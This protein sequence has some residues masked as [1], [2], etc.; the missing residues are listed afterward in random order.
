MRF[1]HFSIVLNRKS[2]L[3]FILVYF[4]ISMVLAQQNTVSENTGTEAQISPPV[5]DTTVAGYAKQKK[6][7]ITGAITTVKSDEFNKGNIN[8]PLQLIQGKVA[9]IGISKPGGD[10]NGL[11]DIRI[12]G[13]NTINATANPLIVID[14]IADG[15]LDNVDPNDIESITVLKDASAAAIYGTRASNGVL[16]VTTKR[17]IKGSAVEYN[18]FVTTESVAKN[19]LS[20]NSAG[21]RALSAE[22]GLGTDFGNNT[23]WF[24]EIEQRAISQVHNISI[25]GGTDK[26][27][28]RASVNFRQGE[29]IEIHTG[30]SQ[31]NGRFNLSQK[32]INDKLTLDLNLSATE[33]KSQYGFREAFKY[34][35]IFNP[36]AP[37]R[38]NDP[39]YSIYDGYFQQTLFDYY[40]PVAILDLNTNDGKNSVLNLS[41]KGTYEVLEGLK[42]D[43]LYSFQSMGNLK[44]EYYDKNDFWIGIN[45][46][47]YASRQKDNLSFQLFETTA[48][49][50]GDLSSDISLS[51]HG[52][53]SYQDFTQEGFNVNGGNFLTD[54]FSYNNLSAALDFNNG[55][56]IADSYKK[57]NKLIAFF[58]QFTL[59][60][61]SLWFVSA[62]SRYEGSSRFGSSRKWGLFPSI[63]TGIELANFINKKS[64]NSL[65]L[66]MGY[67]ITGN[68]PKDSYLSLLHLEQIGS[69]LYNG[70]YIPAYE[71]FSN[72]NP[73]LKWEQNNEFNIGAD[74]ALFGFRLSGS[75]DIYN[76][77][78]TDLLYRYYSVNPNDYYYYTWM[79]L[80]EISN[81]G[82]ELTLNYKVF[83]KS[84]FTYITALSLSR[85]KNILVSL[86]GT[87]NGI[88]IKPEIYDM[89]YMGSPG[90]SSPPVIRIEEGKPIG[91]I[92]AYTF[93]EIDENGNLLLEDISGPNKVP[94]GYV[95]SYDRSVVGNGLPKILLG[96][97]NSFIYKN[98]D[99]NIFFRGVFGHDLINSNRA[100]YESPNVIS[101]YNPQRTTT[102]MRNPKTGALQNTYY[103]LFSSIHV[104]N[105]SFVSLDNLNLGYSINLPDNKEISKIRFYFAGNNL[106]YLT[107]YKGSDPNPRY[108]DNE[109]NTY[110]PL[111]AGIDRRETWPRTRS[112]SFGVNV[113]F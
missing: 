106:F 44:S 35:T 25:V 101:S 22:T 15:S 112:V 78:S 96:F 72:E 1:L 12:R 51:A 18:F 37:V 16:L 70:T 87:Y 4:T 10:P 29:G 64:V 111:I 20:M 98:W 7:N 100:F 57:T 84:D 47:G 80:G 77:K 36:T 107:G 31:F 49:Y 58:G 33:R 6:K 50:S 90:G 63:G 75:F 67:G 56:G 88:S 66:R 103:G 11:Y 27:I 14:G 19:P 99:L 28:Y 8:N 32:A 43:A 46:N 93:K 68:Q 17:G 40:N 55:Y 62:S 97:G 76:R 74:F 60:F 34:A 71:Q 39:A 89:G 21:W 24:K 104:E 110:N 42:V 73:N 108:S 91:Q 48:N 95:D 26:T 113:I 105:A 81:R 82:F 92:L 5:V 109:Y 52:G 41:L 13:L 38:N 86:S 94:D 59:N 9:G 53:Y 85:N 83:Q 30:Y 54:A 23:D 79:N 2:I 102:N 69:T 65:K 61:N 45:R 3:S